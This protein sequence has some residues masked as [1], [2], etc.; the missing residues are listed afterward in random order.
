MRRFFVDGITEHNEVWIDGTDAHHIGKVLRLKPGAQVVVVTAAGEEYDVI[1]EEILPAKVRGSVAGQRESSGEP[2]LEVILIQGLPKG[3]KLELIIQKCT[4][5]GIAEIWPVCTERSIVRYT[6]KKAEERRERWQRIAREAA[7][8]CR[9]QR[10]PRVMDVLSWQQAMQNITGDFQGILLWES[11]DTK[12][13]KETL[14]SMNCRNPVYV[15]VGP[16]GG[17]TKEEV[18][19]A[20][21]KGVS[22]VTLGPRILRTETAGM[23]AL[24][25]IMYQLGDLGSGEPTCK[26]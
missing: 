19:L 22:T 24:S 6:G 4:E 1:L 20:K 5:L 11:E 25:I 21:E 18:A 3:D 17:F 26:K 10:I 23:A 12:S 7:K 8:Q 9:R 15:F 16:E 14:F 13:L 2:P